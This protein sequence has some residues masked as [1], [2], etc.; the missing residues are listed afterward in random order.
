MSLISLT[1]STSTPEIGQAFSKLSCVSF[2]KQGFVQ[3]LSYKNEYY[4]HVYEN[5]FS[6]ERLC[7]KTRF[8]KEVPDNSKMAYS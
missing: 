3:N 8:E 5:S 6:Y 7:T 2:S 4:L 1:V